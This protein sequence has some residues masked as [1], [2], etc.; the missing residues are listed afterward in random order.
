MFFSEPIFTGL[1]YTLELSSNSSISS[2][3]PYDLYIA[4][5]NF[6]PISIIMIAEKIDCIMLISGMSSSYKWKP[7]ISVSM[8]IAKR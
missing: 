7:I 6:K 4:T 5:K 2:S 3:S 1:C 8:I